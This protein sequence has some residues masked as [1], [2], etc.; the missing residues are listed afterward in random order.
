MENPGQAGDSGVFLPEGITLNPRQR[1]KIVG[2]FSNPDIMWQ[3]DAA[4]T[5]KEQEAFVKH[6]SRRQ[7]SDRETI[8]NE[9]RELVSQVGGNILKLKC[10]PMLEKIKPDRRVSG[11]LSFFTR[12][13]LYRRH[14]IEA[15]DILEFLKKY[16]NPYRFQDKARDF[17][18]MIEVFNTTAKRELYETAMKTF[19]E[20]LYGKQFEYLM[21]INLIKKEAKQ[22]YFEK[23]N[24]CREVLRALSV[25][26]AAAEEAEEVLKLTEVHG[27]PFNGKSLTPAIL[28]QKGLQPKYKLSIKGF[29]MGFCSSAYRIAQGRIAAI[30]YMSKNGKWITRSYYLS[31][32]HAVW[33]YL[34]G[35]AMVEGRIVSYGIGGK[36]GSTDLPMIFQKA[37]S[38]IVRDPEVVIQLPDGDNEFIFAGTSYNIAFKI[39]EKHGSSPDTGIKTVAAIESSPQ[40]LG[41]NFY[42]TEEKLIPPEKVIFSDQNQVPDFSKF[43]TGWKSQSSVYGKVT[44]EVFLSR[45]DRLI[46]T[47]CRD[48][49]GRIWLGCIENHSAIQPAG[50]R[51]T[52]VDGGNL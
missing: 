48:D 35:Y 51:A 40:K 28:T 49:G 12:C 2:S 45:D 30:A 32:S 20:L 42:S 13:S 46:Y 7:I 37:L 24:I 17:L 25:E 16:P 31:N 47:F 23:S 18:L 43:I 44:Y 10:R 1:R 41:G 33:R 14:E 19:M 3:R 4:I 5:E 9:F 38:L 29:E 26:P 6:V 36:R 11:I 50:I 34:E 15:E 21:Q 52:W 27:S 39:S 22:V 8:E